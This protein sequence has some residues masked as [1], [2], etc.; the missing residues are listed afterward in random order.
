[1][2]ECQAVSK[3]LGGASAQC[4]GDTLPRFAASGPIMYTDNAIRGDI[5][6]EFHEGLFVVATQVCF[7]A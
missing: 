5:H 6:N 2:G 4:D 1:L 7:R 3:L